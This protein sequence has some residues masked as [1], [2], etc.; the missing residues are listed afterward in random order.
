MC[1][2]CSLNNLDASGQATDKVDSIMPAW[3][4]L[5]EYSC[6]SFTNLTYILS[7]QL[8]KCYDLNHP[9]LKYLP[10]VPSRNHCT[11]NSSSV[12][13]YRKSDQQSWHSSIMTNIDKK[14]CHNYHLENPLKYVSRERIKIHGITK[15]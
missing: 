14:L 3:T 13:M 9:A 4:K 7:K 10:L 1:D 5:N 11:W 15:C 2:N 12:A 8:L 6:H